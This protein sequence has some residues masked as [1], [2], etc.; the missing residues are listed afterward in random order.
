MKD[1][2][3]CL[4]FGID[5]CLLLYAFFLCCV[6]KI[7]CSRGYISLDGLLVRCCVSS[8]KGSSE[9][10]LDAINERSLTGLKRQ[11]KTKRLKKTKKERNHRHSLGNF[12][13]NEGQ[14]D[15]SFVPAQET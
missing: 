14:G 11:K 3:G 2:L 6:G 4:L 15:G 13:Q 9:E 7:F 10:E 1:N 5:V 12:L 8:A